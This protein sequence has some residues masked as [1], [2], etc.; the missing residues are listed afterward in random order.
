MIVVNE[1]ASD[2]KAAAVIATVLACLDLIVLCVTMG[3]R[4]KDDSLLL[5]V[6]RRYLKLSKPRVSVVEQC[7]GRL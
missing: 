2:R 1:L 7:L 6:Y 5:A 4:L 3:R